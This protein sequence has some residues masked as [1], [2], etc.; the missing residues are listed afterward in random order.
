MGYK[1]AN[2]TVS[3]VLSGGIKAQ[4]RRGQAWSTDSKVVQ[5]RPELFDDDPVEIH[6][7]VFDD[8]PVETATAAAGEKRP[9]KRAAKRG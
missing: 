2:Q 7:V 6:G 4:I 9:T 1:F 8:A 3:P 5:E